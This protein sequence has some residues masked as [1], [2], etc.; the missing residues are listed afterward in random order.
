MWKVS[1]LVA[2]MLLWCPS[3]GFGQTNMASTND[4]VLIGEFD[5][6]LGP[7]LTDAY[8]CQGKFEYVPAPTPDRPANQALSITLDPSAPLGSG[9]CSSLRGE[10][11]EAVQLRLPLRT[12]VWY[13]FRFMLPFYM[14]GKIGSGHLVLA[15]LKQRAEAQ[16]STGKTP[17]SS[18]IDHPV[19]PTKADGNPTIAVRVF[20][21]IGSGIAATQLTV[22]SVN[23]KRIAVGAVLRDPDDFYGTWHTL[24]IH[25]YVDP[26]AEGDA[27]ANKKGFVEGFLDR[28]AFRRD[29]YGFANGKPKWNEPFGYPRLKGCD[30]FKFGLYG[31]PTVVP[32]NVLIDRFRRGTTRQDVEPPPG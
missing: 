27:D 17:M 19:A 9:R 20:E 22:S 6:S 10:V 31:D 2:T 26:R 18:R 16:C 12:D 23:V 30:Y 21:D 4:R 11:S 7:D 8:Q 24:L 15:Q 5:G 13:G 25:A 28:Q 32:W 29:P 14:K 1:I 3:S